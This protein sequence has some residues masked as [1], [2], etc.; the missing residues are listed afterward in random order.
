MCGVLERKVKF[1]IKNL[2]FVKLLWNIIKN[3][4]VYHFIMWYR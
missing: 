1:I 3:F 2:K 4:I